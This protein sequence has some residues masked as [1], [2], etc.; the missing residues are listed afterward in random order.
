MHCDDEALLHLYGIPQQESFARELATDM[1]CEVVIL[2]EPSGGDPF[3]EVWSTLWSRLAARYP[4][5]PIPL[6]CCSTT[7]EYRGEADVNDRLAKA[8]AEGLFRFLQRSGL[9]A[10]DPGPAPAT[11]VTVYQLN[12]I[13][14]V[15]TATAGILSYRVGL[16]ERVESGAVIADLIDPAADNPAEGRRTVTCQGAGVVLSLRL[17]K[18]VTPGMAVAKIAGHQALDHRTG[19]LLSD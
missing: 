5:R 4:D 17:H 9:I 14:M 1:G 12:A 10:G 8:D 2:S 15:R 6:A 16:G 11:A 3:D 18:Y 19:N 13:D 7:L